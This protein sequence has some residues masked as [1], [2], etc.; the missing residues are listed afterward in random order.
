MLQLRECHRYSGNGTTDDVV[1][2]GQVVLMHNE[3]S[4]RGFWKMVRIHELIR[5]GDGLVRGAVLKVPSR[6]TQP[7]LLRRPLKCLYPLEECCRA[8]PVKNDKSNTVQSRIPSQVQNALLTR[9]L[10]TTLVTLDLRRMRPTVKFSQVVYDH[11]GELLRRQIV[12]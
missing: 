6:D 12:L 1:R 3:S 8:K 9:M 7:T 5:G 10:V 11:L 4:P 2:E